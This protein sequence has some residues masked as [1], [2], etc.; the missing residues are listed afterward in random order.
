MV[1]VPTNVILKKEKDEELYRKHKTFNL[2]KN[3]QKTIPATQGRE[4]FLTKGTENTNHTGKERNQTTL[5]IHNLHAEYH[6]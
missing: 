5:K 2:Q 1:H 6:I 3:M 4:G